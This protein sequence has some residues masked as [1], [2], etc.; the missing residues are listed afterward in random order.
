MGSYNVEE[1][2]LGK[3]SENKI[4]FKTVEDMNEAYKDLDNGKDIC[5]VKDGIVIK[6]LHQLIST[7]VYDG[8]LLF[9]AKEGV[10][11]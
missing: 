8:T 1:Y 4:V 5:I 2:V 7:K 10:K 11:K 3:P 6:L 9:C